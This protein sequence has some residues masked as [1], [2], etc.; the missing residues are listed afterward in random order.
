MTSHYYVIESDIKDYLASKEFAKFEV[1]LT[2]LG[3]TIQPGERICLT[4]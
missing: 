1:D 3:S 4:R 2:F